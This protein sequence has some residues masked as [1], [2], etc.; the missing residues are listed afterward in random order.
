MMHFHKRR[1]TKDK[2]WEV[3]NVRTGRKLKEREGQ[4]KDWKE[5]EGNRRTVLGE[6]E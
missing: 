2:L 4:T 3:M 6:R 1:K 5:I